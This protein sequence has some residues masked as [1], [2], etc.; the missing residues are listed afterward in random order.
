MFDRCGS[1]W[2]PIVTEARRPNNQALVAVRRKS[3]G[4]ETVFFVAD[5]TAR[6]LLSHALLV[7][8][9]RTARSALALFQ[10]NRRAGLDSVVWY[11]V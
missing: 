3:A 2:T 1:A 6:G 4:D 5:R 10:E 8:E 9:D 7:L 11:G